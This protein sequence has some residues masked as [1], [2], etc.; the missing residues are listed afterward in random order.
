M[1][2]P[3]L[4]RHDL[5]DPAIP[6]GMVRI[7]LGS[8]YRFIWPVHLGGWQSLGWQMQSTGIEQ[9]PEPRLPE[10]LTEAEPEPTL[11]A[12]GSELQSTP[13]GADLQSAPLGTDLQ[14]APLGATFQ[15]MTKA[16][17]IEY[18]STVYGVEL[19]G[20]QTKTELIQQAAALED[21]GGSA[22]E[23]QEGQEAMSCEPL[24]DALVDDPLI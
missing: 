1:A 16:Q 21:Q 8:R 20:S 19:D 15:A 11:P 2:M 13:P 7:V 5:S 18:C 22:T 14:S 23:P 10:L 17:I 6:E 9:M 24:P 12:A 3:S 4:I